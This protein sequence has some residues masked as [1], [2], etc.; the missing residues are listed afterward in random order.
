MIQ[1][2]ES[3]SI[4]SNCGI[5]PNDKPFAIP[6]IYSDHIFLRLQVPYH[7]V[8]ANGGG[9]PIGG[10]CTV[11]LT[12]KTGMVNYCSYGALTSGE[13]V[14]NFINDAS[15]RKAEYRVMLPLRVTGHNH[16]TKS[17]SLTVGDEVVVDIDGAIYTW[18]YGIDQTPY[19]FIDYAAGKVCVRNP[20]AAVMTILVNGGGIIPVSLFTSDHLPCND[21]T[22]FRVQFSVNFSGTIYDFTT[23]MFQVLP[24]DEES[25]FVESEYPDGTVDCAGQYHYGSS[26]SLY[27]NKNY[28]RIPAGLERI[29]SNIKKTYNAKCFQFK[30]E[31]VKQQRLKSDPI[32]DWY[33]DA[34][35]TL[36]LGRNFKVD[37]N[38]FLIE[39][40][41]IFENNDVPGTTFQN[42]NVVL[43]QCKCEKVFVC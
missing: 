27:A 13:F 6:L 23:K 24:C 2:F 22:C 12:D 11:K 8:V 14:Y 37:G 9:L 17:F 26:S 32:P 39:A 4:D 40:E 3:T 42:I 16:V 35:E 29:P 31:I 41:N 15:K 25:V 30:S 18:L 7:L 43:Q 36:M 10:N 21:E 1:L 38:P 20:T 33:Q 34:C 19:P 5:G 28:L